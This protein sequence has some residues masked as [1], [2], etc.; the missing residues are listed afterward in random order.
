MS[1]D[2]TAVAD[3]Q[4]RRCPNC[5]SVVGAD[6]TRCLMCGVALTPS[7]TSPPS[8]PEPPVP[9]PEPELEPD[10]ELVS[11]NSEQ[12]VVDSQE[13]ES[14]ELATEPEPTEPPDDQLLVPDPQ[15]PLPQPTAVFE[16]TM[17]EKQSPVVALMT[18]VAAV[19]IIILGALCCG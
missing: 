14:A 15:S 5:D 17:R 13:T 16:S 9:I 8:T 4:V 10:E 2:V 6:D 11:E 3:N 19:F 12:L 7:P 18:A 1:D